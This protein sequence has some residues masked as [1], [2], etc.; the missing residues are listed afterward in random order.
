MMMT[1]FYAV[2]EEGREGGGADYSYSSI[3][4]KCIYTMISMIVEIYEH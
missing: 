4:Q 2:C 3:S 1:C